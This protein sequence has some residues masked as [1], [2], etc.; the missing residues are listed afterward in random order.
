MD[1]LEQPALESR[2][3]MMAAACVSEV[4][5]YAVQDEPLSRAQQ[6]RFYS[7]VSK[8]LA[9][10]PLAYLTCSKEF[11][12]LDFHVFPGVLIPRPETELLVETVLRLS[13]H[14]EETIVDIGTGCGNIAVSLATELPQARIWGTDVSRKA[15][16]A[17][18]L[19]A[20]RHGVHAIHFIMGSLWDPLEKLG[21]EGRCDFIVSNPPYVSQGQWA[22]LERP[23][24]THEPRTA[25]VS[26]ETGL[27]SIEKLVAGSPPFLGD[28][29]FLILEIG[30]GQKDAVLSL[31]RETWE[32]IEV[33]EDLGGI[34]RVVKARK[35]S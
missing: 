8:R 3:L 35:K 21:M 23:I 25:L 22:D 29:G 26:G 16:K 20:S 15:L 10:W 19:N 11:W 6:R 17:A 13:T 27:E 9:G 33:F 2:L 28:R 34:P 1:K 4:Q 14:D 7:L 5:F 24:K 12:S 30:C 18:R 31:F 32:D